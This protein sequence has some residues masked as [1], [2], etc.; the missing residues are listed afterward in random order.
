MLS[1]GTEQAS[2]VIYVLS[3]GRESGLLALAKGP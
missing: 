1:P 3:S 2:T